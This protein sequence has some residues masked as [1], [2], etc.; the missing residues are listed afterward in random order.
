M[1]IPLK[2]VI[3]NQ[4]SVFNLKEWIS[5]LIGIESGASFIPSKVKSIVRLFIFTTQYDQVDMYVKSAFL[6]DCTPLLFLM[7]DDVYD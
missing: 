7:L 5:E 3:I 2:Q 6:R 4:F 1:N